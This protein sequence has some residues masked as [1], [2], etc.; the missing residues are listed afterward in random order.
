MAIQSSINQA[1]HSVAQLG[2]LSKIGKEAEKTS[3][4]SE[5]ASEQAQEQ[6][7]TQLKISANPSQSQAIAQEALKQLQ[8]QQEQKRRLNL[9]MKNRYEELK[10]QGVTIMP[11]KIADVEKGLKDF[12]KEIDDRITI[13]KKGGNK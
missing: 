2:A 3:V 12:N 6:Y 10:N 4:A 7:K 1:I 13:S 11:K 8:A 5:K 9:F